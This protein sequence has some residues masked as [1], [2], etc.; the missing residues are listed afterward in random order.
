MTPARR[1]LLLKS[2]DAPDWMDD[3]RVTCGTC[4]HRSRDRCIVLRTWAHLPNLKHFCDSHSPQ[5]AAR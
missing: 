3:E 1:D 5:R 4:A 2:A